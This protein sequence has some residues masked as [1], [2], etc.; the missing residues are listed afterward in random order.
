MK[1]SIIWILVFLLVLVACAPSKQDMLPPDLEVAPKVMEETAPPIIIE[2]TRITRNE[3]ST[4]SS[5]VI[6]EV[7]QE[8]TIITSLLELVPTTYWFLDHTTGEGAVVNGTHRRSVVYV[9]RGGIDTG[10]FFWEEGKPDFY[11]SVGD[12]NKAWLYDFRGI[13][14]NVT[15]S[16]V[17]TY[18]E[19]VPAFFFNE[20]PRSQDEIKA[21]LQLTA[22][23][24]TKA[25]FTNRPKGPV[26]WMQEYKNQMP[27]KTVTL[28]RKEK[29][30]DRE[31]MQTNL[32]LYFNKINDVNHVIS[33]V[34]DKKFHVPIVIDEYNTNL[35]MKKNLAS[36][37]FD[38][39]T[40]ISTLVIPKTPLFNFTN[41][42]DDRVILN[43][44]EWDA[45]YTQVLDN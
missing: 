31:D 39:A 18:Q 3:S 26:E 11:Y 1:Y 30:L 37:T 21:A 36:Y 4:E 33:L 6:K 25:S 44:K 41:V 28:E 19:S 8:K 7:V 5:P 43:Q 34:F 35:T 2:E 40:R 17:D 24:K 13:K 16:L 29:V 12:I 23:N 9:G 27:I 15:K 10:S 42:P 45:Y 32:T 14:R 38:T 22:E 20:I